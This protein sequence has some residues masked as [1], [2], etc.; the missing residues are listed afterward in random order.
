MIIEIL[1]DSLIAKREVE[2][3]NRVLKNS[4]A[5]TKS[6]AKECDVVPLDIHSA[7]TSQ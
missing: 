3:V 6:Q 7:L 1:C 4:S 2:V 5:R